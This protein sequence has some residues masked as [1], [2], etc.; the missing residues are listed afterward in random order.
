[1]TGQIIWLPTTIG[2]NA[3]SA[4]EEATGHA[5]LHWSR[6]SCQRAIDGD[7]LWKGLFEPR[8]FLIKAASRTD[9]KTK[10]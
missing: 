1:M 8:A 6:E 2:A 3:K 5:G 4:I 10:G 9:L 7:R